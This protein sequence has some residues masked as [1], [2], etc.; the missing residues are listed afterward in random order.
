MTAAGV[1]RAV[2]GGDDKGRWQPRR[3]TSSKEGLE[4]K[5]SRLGSYKAKTQEKEQQPLVWGEQQE[6]VWEKRVH[7]LLR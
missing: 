4:K 3:V 5:Q 7:D 2:V 6:E 1:V